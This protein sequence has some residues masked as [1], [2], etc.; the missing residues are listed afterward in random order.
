MV[1]VACGII[2]G[3]R[4]DGY[5][6]Q[7]RTGPRLNFEND[8]VL[9]VGDYY[10]YVP[11]P[12]DGQHDVYFFLVAAPVFSPD[13]R[14]GMTRNFQIPDRPHLCTLEVPA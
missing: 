7:H 8:E 14:I 1:H 13:S 2:V 4:W 9:P 10:Y 3:N 5:F 6:T 11:D 12:L